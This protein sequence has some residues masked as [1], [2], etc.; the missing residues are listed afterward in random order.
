MQRKHPLSQFLRIR[1]ICTDIKDYDKHS[2]MLGQHFLRR[3]YPL[4]L[5]ENAV[6]KVRRLDRPTLLGPKTVHDSESDEDD[7]VIMVTTYNPYENTVRDLAKKN[8]DLMGKSTKTAFLHEKRLMTAYR[9][10]QNLMDLLVRADC[11]IKQPQNQAKVEKKQATLDNFL[12]LRNVQSAVK[13]SSS[14]SNLTQTHQANPRISRSSSHLVPK[15]LSKNMCTYKK[16]RYCPLI[17]TSGHIDCTGLERHLM[18]NQAL[19]A[20]AQISS[21]VSHV[22]HVQNSMWD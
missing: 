9:R 7:R 15:N 18:L 1:R 3:G 13:A 5:I 14:T 6:I 21:T 17:Y 2:A 11:Q 12:Q 8:W 16:C 4:Y 20:R 19:T 22:K 10:P